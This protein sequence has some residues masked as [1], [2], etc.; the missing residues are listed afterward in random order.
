MH[1]GE[2]EYGAGGIGSD[3]FNVTYM[4]TYIQDYAP[5]TTNCL[6]CHNQTNASVR[7]YWGN[8]TLIYYNRSNQNQYIGP[9]LM[10]GATNLSDCYF[11]HTNN[12]GT[13]VNFH[14]A[15]LEPGRACHTCHFNYT[16]MRGEFNEPEKWLNE[17]LFRNSVHGNFSFIYC[18]NCHTMTG[19]H[20]PPE[21]RW[22]WCEDC[23]VVMPQDSQGIPQINVQQRH[24]LTFKPQYSYLNDSGTIKSVVNVTDCTLC[25]NST[26]YNQARA[27]FNRSSGKDCRF[28]HSFPDLNP[29]S[30]F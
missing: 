12:Q 16:I 9:E 26:I 2:L 14:A 11:C 7:R 30:P 5:N 29:D 22:R 23:H 13:P 1:Y 4:N 18:N 6:W 20:P 19:G 27:T 8:A 10:Y 17:T 15:T 21:A 24:N 25:H 28:C 3:Y